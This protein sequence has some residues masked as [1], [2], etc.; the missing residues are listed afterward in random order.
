MLRAH[1][2]LANALPPHSPGA[3][4]IFPAIAA[5]AIHLQPAG[6]VC[7]TRLPDGQRS[8]ARTESES[9]DYPLG[10]LLV[11]RIL[12]SV[13]AVVVAHFHMGSVSQL[14]SDGSAALRVGVLAQSLADRREFVITGVRPSRQPSKAGVRVSKSS[15]I[16]PRCKVNAVSRCYADRVAE[17][18]RRAI[19]A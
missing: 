14:V 19:E 13:V 1:A 5:T 6:C 16:L 7:W 2:E 17:R 8:F 15:R 9:Q 12:R 11:G 3:L 10:V 18:E 4:D